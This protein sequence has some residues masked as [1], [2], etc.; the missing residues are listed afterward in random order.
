VRL[1]YRARGAANYEP[2]KSGVLTFWNPRGRDDVNDPLIDGRG[3]WFFG[4]GCITK[5][6]RM[7]PRT[8]RYVPVVGA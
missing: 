8:R 6:E 5:V 4:T 1:T 2:T 3:G 7:D